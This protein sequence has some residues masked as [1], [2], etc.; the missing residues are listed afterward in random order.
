MISRAEIETFATKIVEPDFEG[1]QLEPLI[2]H[3]SESEQPG[4]FGSAGLPLF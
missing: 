4:E 2:G 1:G 3:L